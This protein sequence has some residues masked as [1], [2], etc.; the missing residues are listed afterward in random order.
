MQVTDNLFSMVEE[1][2]KNVPIHPNKVGYFSSS[3]SDFE[4]SDHQSSINLSNISTIMDDSSSIHNQHLLNQNNS[5]ND[6]QGSFNNEFNTINDYQQS[7]Q[8]IQHYSLQNLDQQNH[9]QESQFSVDDDLLQT[10]PETLRQRQLLSNQMDNEIF[11]PSTPALLRPSVSMND[12]PSSPWIYSSLI[13]PNT[14]QNQHNYI[15]EARQHVNSASH[16]NPGNHLNLGNHSNLTYFPRTISIPISNFDEGD[17]DSDYLAENDSSD[18]EDH[19]LIITNKPISESTSECS[20]HSSESSH[21]NSSQDEHSQGLSEITNRELDKPSIDTD[22]NDHLSKSQS[23]SEPDLFPIDG[24]E[25]SHLHWDLFKMDFMTNN[26]TDE[27]TYESEDDDFVESLSEDDENWMEMCVSEEEN[28]QTNEK[29]KMEKSVPTYDT[30]NFFY[31]EKLTPLDSKLTILDNSSPGQ[32]IRETPL[33]VTL[34][35]QLLSHFQLL[36]TNYLLSCREKKDTSVLKEL[37]RGLYEFRNDKLVPPNFRKAWDQ[38]NLFLEVCNEESIPKQAKRKK[39]NQFLW[40]CLGIFSKSSN[41]PLDPHILGVIDYEIKGTRS[42]F[43]PAEDQLLALGIEI[44]GTDFSKIAENLLPGKNEQQVTNRVR[45]ITAKKSKNNPIYLTLER[46]KEKAKNKLLNGIRMYGEDFKKISY[47]LF[48]REEPARALTLLYKEIERELKVEALQAHEILKK[49]RT[50][51]QRQHDDMR[52]KMA[53]PILAPG[54]GS[55]DDFAGIPQVIPLADGGTIILPHNVKPP[56][57]ISGIQ[58]LL[59]ASIQAFR[60][61]DKDIK[62]DMNPTQKQVQNPIT[63]QKELNSLEHELMTPN[64]INFWTPPHNKRLRDESYSPNSRKRIKISTPLLDTPSGD[65]FG[66]SQSNGFSNINYDS[67]REDTPNIMTSESIR[68]LFQSKKNSEENPQVLIDNP[69]SA[70]NDRNLYTNQ[71]NAFNNSYFNQNSLESSPPGQISLLES[72]NDQ[73][74]TEDEKSH[75]LQTN[76]SQYP[77]STSDYQYNNVQ[78]TLQNI[79]DTEKNLAHVQE[80]NQENKTELAWK[81]EELAYVLR[82]L[83]LCGTN[84]ES[85]ERMWNSD[86]E[87]GKINRNNKELQNQAGE[88]LKK[89]SEF[90]QKKM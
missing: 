86:R 47:E 28:N 14:K 69:H 39:K 32:K 50:E 62:R 23:S 15:N 44:Y 8:E 84:S 6:L 64:D 31:E 22:S 46:R 90:K 36:L 40:E 55:H 89:F 38:I 67:F 73:F 24:S 27:D 80:E 75:S 76:S 48:D 57:G 53:Y 70:M 35:A 21:E 56:P 88:L 52:L 81:K 5:N 18:E 13:T 2:Y 1:E 11:Q 10:S 17:S 33:Q 26:L 74:Y 87:S 12:L 49:K 42:I 30:M 65:M 59:P 72:Q 45:N 63:P 16:V 66:D 85:L 71:I 19:E 4:D 51:R 58:S 54:M 82:T 34:K 41:L 9:S 68:Q 37:L 7:P 25:L 20:N 83:K 43:M 60:F 61:E 77:N 78:Y 29:K 79:N 3:F